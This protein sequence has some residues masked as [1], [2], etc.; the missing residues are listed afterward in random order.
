VRLERETEPGTWQTVTTPAGAL[1]DDALP[2]IVVSYTPQPLRG[3]DG[4]DPP[5]EHYHHA[6]WQ[7]V[8]IWSGTEAL[9]ALPLGMYRFSASGLT[10]DAADTEYPYSGTSWEVAS[11]P[12]EVVPAELAFDGA[13]IV[14]GGQA[15]IRVAYAAAD[16]GWR[17]LHDRSAPNSP[18]P[19]SPGV[20]TAVAS[21]A[22]G[23]DP[24]VLSVASEGVDDD[25]TLLSMDVS[26]LAAGAWTVRVDDGHG[27]VG[28]ALMELP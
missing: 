8:D 11:E 19:L 4:A 13:P 25:W 20:P 3:T 7:A 2:D 28:D 16:G 10:R 14:E 5:R 27:N 18:T 12:F 9:G 6:Q 15:G 23:G 26:A 21:L 17:M 24:V 1:L 22:S